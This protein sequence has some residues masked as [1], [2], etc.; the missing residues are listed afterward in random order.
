MSQFHGR[1]PA[2]LPIVTLHVYVL[3]GGL[4]RA[5]KRRLIKGATAILD[6]RPDETQITPVYVVAEENLARSKRVW[7]SA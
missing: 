2:R 7:P 5:G 3:A 4:D 6:R 1:R